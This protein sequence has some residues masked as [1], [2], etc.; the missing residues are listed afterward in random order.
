MEMIRIPKPSFSRW[1]SRD[2]V[3]Y[4]VVGDGKRNLENCRPRVADVGLHL[5]AR[6]T[7]M[8]GH[9]IEVSETGQVFDL[10]EQKQTSLYTV[11]RI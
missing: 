11:F 7:I 2:G 8:R 5:R 3:R 1:A 9:S 6:I 10:I 4:I